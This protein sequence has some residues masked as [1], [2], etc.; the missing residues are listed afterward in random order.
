VP[1]RWQATVV[2]GLLWFLMVAQPVV[3]IEEG[4]LADRVQ[5]YLQADDAGQAEELLGGLL[6]DRDA[7]VE[8][9]ERVIKAGPVYG[10]APVGM[11]PGMPV[12]VGGLP[13]HYGLYV[14]PSYRPGKDHALVIC[15]HGAGFT[16]DAYLERWQARLGEDYILA[17][18]TFMQGTW[19][20]RTAEELVLATIRD[21][22]RRYRIDPDRVFLTGM[23]NGGIGAYLIG[24]HHAA[25]L[26]GIAPMAAGLDQVLLPLVENLRNTPVYII[27]G[28]RDEVMPVEMSRSMQQELTRLGYAHVYREHDRVHP[29]AG[30]HFFPREELPEL[31]AWFGVQRRDPLPK[32]LTVVRDATHLT[33]FGWVRIDAT[34]PIAAFSEQLIDRKDEALVKRLYARMEARIAGPNRIE[35]STQ[36]VR[37]YTLFLNGGM[38]DLSKPVTVMTDGRVS[39]EGS[40]APT[41]EAMLKDARGRRD[42]RQVFPARVTIG[43]D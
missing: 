17:C 36:R 33:A 6:A 20:T 19:W 9:V 40:V 14:P 29:M 10:R 12:R 27:H 1:G 8:A 11:Q 15:L 35:V 21:V 5:A 41:V 31:V 28:R 23:S 16:G 24:S 3:G 34:D 25:R 13:Y 32:A 30:G 43:V 42:R 22:T 37:R 26:A 4:S 39:F 18:P 2:L 7:T 38:V